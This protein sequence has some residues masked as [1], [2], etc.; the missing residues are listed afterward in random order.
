MS[1]YHSKTMKTAQ[2]KITGQAPYTQSRFHGEAKLPREGSEDYEN[3][4]WPGKAHLNEAEQVTIPALAFKKCL[5]EAAKYLS[6]QIPGKGK[7]TYTKHFQSGVIVLTDSVVSYK[8]QPVTKALLDVPKSGYYGNRM[9]VPS[10]GVAGSGKRVFR[11]FPTVADGWECVVEFLIMDDIITQPVFQKHL[12]M[13]G[14]LIGVGAFRVRN[15]GVMG[16][17]KSEI[18]SWT[19]DKEVA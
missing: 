15:G 14:M 1:S 11:T 4:T 16:R 19:E 12:T 7:A 13:A 10:D 18:L 17:F 9:F 2:V 8:G 3:R 6:E 5:A